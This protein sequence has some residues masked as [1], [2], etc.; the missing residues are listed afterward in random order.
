MVKG[1][2]SA[3]CTWESTFSAVSRVMCTDEVCMGMVVA[4]A[5]A[6][7]NAVHMFSVR[8]PSF[9]ERPS[10]PSNMETCPSSMATV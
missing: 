7:K 10:W 3:F 5:E 1:C 9:T 8:A 2:E 4:C 6:S